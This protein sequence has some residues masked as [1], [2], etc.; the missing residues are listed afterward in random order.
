M[1]GPV[2]E[3]SALANEPLPQYQRLKVHIARQ[4]E[5]GRL[6]PGQ[7]IPSEQELVR[8]FSVSRMTVSRALNDLEQDGAITRIQGVGSF[9]STGKA[10]SALLEI[11]DIAKEIA[12]RGQTHSSRPLH[13]AEERGSSINALLGLDADAAC[14]HTVLLH[15]ADGQPV[16]VEDRWVNPR[17]APKYIAQDFNRTTPHRYL[18]SLAPLQAAEHVFEADL[19][20]PKVAGWLGIPKNTPCTILRRR[21]WS[22]NLVASVAT[23][24]TASHRSRY[25][26]IF[27]SL[28]PLAKALPRL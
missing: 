22:L 5:A 20:T 19:P 12:D 17:F 28:P 13:I 15:L 6:K 25:A 27:G 14:Y 11:R 3:K 16:Q 24:V 21:T 1:R 7:R 26:G 10:E 18:M 2:I 23:L 9:V 8:E 4:I